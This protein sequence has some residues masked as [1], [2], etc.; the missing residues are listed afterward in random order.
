MQIPVGLNVTKWKNTENVSYRD[1]ILKYS[2]APENS[3]VLHHS[4]SG[5]RKGIRHL[6]LILHQAIP[7]GCSL[8][9]LGERPGKD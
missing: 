8:A 5:D 1:K 3:S 7:K 6:K 9:D 4:W 2:T